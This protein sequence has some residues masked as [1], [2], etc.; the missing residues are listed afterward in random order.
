MITLLT[1][2]IL[3]RI[4]TCSN[5]GAYID[6]KIGDNGTF[7]ENDIPQRMEDW[8][9][10]RNKIVEFLETDENIEVSEDI[11]EQW[12]CVAP[13]VD[14]YSGSNSARHSGSNSAT[15]KNPVIYQIVTHLV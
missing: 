5:L 9:E 3:A 10:D 14:G 7:Y 2:R 8:K 1:Y 13:P 4:W 15:L 6:M 11:E 12:D